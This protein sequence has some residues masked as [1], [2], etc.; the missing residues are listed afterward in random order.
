MI[1]HKT[2]IALVLYTILV[3]LAGAFTF[4]AIFFRLR[5][6]KRQRGRAQVAKARRQRDHSRYHRGAHEVTA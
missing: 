4:R 2:I 6:G 1:D 3:F 5:R